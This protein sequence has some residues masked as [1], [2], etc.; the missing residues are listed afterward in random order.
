M[1]SSLPVPLPNSVG[2]P[3][4]INATSDAAPSLPYFEHAWSVLSII[5]V[6]NVFLGLLIIGITSFSKL[7]VVPIVS[8][9]AGA[10]ANGLYFHA[11]Y[12]KP[13][14]LAKRAAAA[15][16]GDICWLIQEAGL[17]FYSFII[18]NRL[19]RGTK[20]RVFHTVFW[21]TL[22]LVTVV[23]VVI[24]Y[25]RLLRILREDD[26]LQSIII[27]IHIAYF[28]LFAVSECVS[29]YFL[30]HIF[31]EVR[32]SSKEAGLRTSFI[33]YLMRSTEIRVASLA[34]AAAIRVIT[35][36]LNV[37]QSSPATRYVDRAAYA[38]GCFF[39][40]IMYVDL[41]ASK[42]QF[43]TQTNDPSFASDRPLRGAV[44]SGKTEE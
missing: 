9:A 33:R 25:Y 16:I 20:R 3:N 15:A 39:P 8:S 18:L 32:K 43:T 44:S 36:S 19:L 5:G 22:V 14:P 1:S 2:M 4:T 29:A 31:A 23:K 12:D 6:F 28:G 35:H 13:Y 24:I 41:L 40:V 7:T 26:S 11:Y 17:P 30:L 27:R 42:L 10:I 37:W 34:V 21:S 38:L